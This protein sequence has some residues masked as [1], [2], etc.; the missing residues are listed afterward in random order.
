[1][2]DGQHEVTFRP[3][4]LDDYEGVLAVSGPNHYEGYD[5]LPDL[6]ETFVKS[7]F[8]RCFVGEIGS[9]IVSQLF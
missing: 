2:E 4:T 3:A 1:M 9:K 6:Y 5:Y 7:P 8:R